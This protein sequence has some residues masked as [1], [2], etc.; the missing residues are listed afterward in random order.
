MSYD[1][2]TQSLINFDSK[3]IIIEPFNQIETINSNLVRVIYVQREFEEFAC[4]SC[5]K[6][7]SRVKE[8]KIKDVRVYFDC[9]GEVII[10][11]RQRRLKCDCG[12]T[13]PEVTPLVAKNKSISNSVRLQ[14]LNLCKKVISFKTIAEMLHISSSSVI[15]TFMEVANFDRQPLGE[16]ISVDEFSYVVNGKTQYAFVIG[17]PMT[18]QLID[19]LPSRKQDDIEEYFSKISYEE[20]LNVKYATM[21]MWKGYI[22]SIK[23]FF[24]NAIIAVDPFHWTRLI[25]NAIHK[26]RRKV[27]EDNI[28]KISYLTKKYW[29]CFSK[30]ENELS[31]IKTYNY[32]LKAKCSIRDIVEVCINSD[33]VFEESW[34]A[35]QDFYKIVDL[36]DPEIVRI[37]LGEWIRKIKSSSLEEM[38]KVANSYTEYFEYIINSF[39]KIS[40]GNDSFIRLTNAFIEGKNKLCKD[41]IQ[42]GCG[43]N[44]FWILRAR[45]LYI[46][47]NGELTFRAD[48]EKKRIKHQNLKFKKRKIKK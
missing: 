12:K 5:G 39:K 33:E 11:Y 1:I 25:T 46:S 30:R 13:F 9:L 22:K 38:K 24:P 47:A 19:I 14:I 36:K 6:M 31:E 2:V 35:L 43:Y 3:L 41:I 34:V 8:Y 20:R 40:I 45:I 48:D 18:R 21:D 26:V 32:T 4:P 37:K 15:N 10:R 42:V 29:R 28:P 44:N 27:H 17:N 16:I 7:V 23:K